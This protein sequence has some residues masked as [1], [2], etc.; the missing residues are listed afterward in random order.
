VHSN[1]SGIR[2]SVRSAPVTASTRA[3]LTTFRRE[4]AVTLHAGPTS[5]TFLP[6]LS[7]L[8]V[9][10][11]H[12]GEDLIAPVESLARY[13]AGHVAG[14]PFL[15]PWA[16]RLG[17]WSYRSGGRRVTVPHDVPVDKQGLPIHG[18]VAGVPFSVDILAADAETMHLS[19]SLDVT[20]AK[21]QPRVFRSF[22]F[23]HV[24]TVDVMLAPG[25]LRIATEVHATTDV[26]V[27]VSF[28]WHPYFELPGSEPREKWRLR[29]PEM[30]HI[31]LDDRQLPL[32]DGREEPATHGPIGDRRFDDHYA[33]A[34]DRRFEVANRRAGLV[35]E[36]DDAYPYAQVYVPPRKNFVCIEPM[37]AEVN[38]LVAGTAPLVVPGGTYRAVWQATVS[39]P[40]RPRR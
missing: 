25:R 5:A 33:L 14:I 30:F 10:F 12:E 27:P 1:A 3:E 15:Y 34:D 13:R 32:T 8:G 26:P 16:N 20:S 22:P 29:L 19:A 24:V 28:G 38:A 21:A 35:V 37:V 39:G 40:S 9:A 6:S 31:D 18:T 23:P 17:A 4:P 36:F 2:E 11:R 7:M